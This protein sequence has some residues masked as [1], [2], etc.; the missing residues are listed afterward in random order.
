M[1]KNNKRIIGMLRRNLLIKLILTLVL[2]TISAPFLYVAATTIFS[3]FIWQGDEFLY[4]LAIWMSQRVDLMAIGYIVGGYT[5]IGVYYFSKPFSYLSEVLDGAESIYRQ[6]E[7]L[8]AFSSSNLSQIESQM[9]QL[10]LTLRSNQRAAQE[11]EK[12]K[13]ELVAYLA[14]DLKTPITSVIGY[15]T[16]LHDEKEI[17]YNLRQRYL[18]ISLDKAQRLDD[19]INEFFEITRFNLSNISLEY[20]RINLTRMLE[21]LLFEFKPML[22]DKNLTCR[23]DC[24]ADV[25]LYC[26]PGKLQRVFDNLLRNAVNYSYPDT[27]IQIS[28]T[29]DENKAH[30]VFVNHGTTISAEKLAR[31]FEQFYRLDSSRTSASGGAGLGLAIAKE[32]IELHNGSI[33]ATSQEETIQFDVFLPLK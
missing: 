22:T 30:L 14:H 15:L 12:R 9:N 19:L 11:A 18:S 24:P 7:E 25:V 23:L 8:I 32:I 27:E 10:K 21:Q 29:L 16:L 20:S 6:D 33:T 4:R 17:S 3:M 1:D 26:D 13:N 2:Y 31:I 5:I 28:L